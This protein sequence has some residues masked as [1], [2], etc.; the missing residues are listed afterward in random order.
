LP[1]PPNQAQ[2]RRQHPDP[3]K[4]R[5]KTDLV[6]YGHPASGRAIKVAL[7]LSLARL[8]HQTR[9]IDI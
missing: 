2:S 7:A 6:L 3:A 1:T 4:A 9:W 8:P 5:S